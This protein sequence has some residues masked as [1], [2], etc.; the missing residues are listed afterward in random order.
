M[1]EKDTK[2]QNIANKFGVTEKQLEDKI[3]KMLKDYTAL[4]EELQ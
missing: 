3:E 1:R 4:E 2:L